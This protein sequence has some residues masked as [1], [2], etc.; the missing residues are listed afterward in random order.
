MGHVCVQARRDGMDVMPFFIAS[1]DYRL[2]WKT[3]L[4]SGVRARKDENFRLILFLAVT[5]TV[6]ENAKDRE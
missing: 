1:I 5:A 4:D 2:F 6:G 3:L